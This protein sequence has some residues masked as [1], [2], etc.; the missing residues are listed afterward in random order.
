MDRFSTRDF[1]L[2]GYTYDLVIIRRDKRDRLVSVRMQSD[3]HHIYDCWVFI[4][5]K[6]QPMQN[7]CYYISFTKKRKLFLVLPSWSNIS[8]YFLCSQTYLEQLPPKEV[9]DCQTCI[10]NLPSHLNSYGQTHGCIRLTS[11]VIKKKKIRRKSLCKPYSLLDC[12]M[13]IGSLT[14]TCRSSAMGTLF[15]CI[16]R[17]EQNIVLKLE[18]L[19]RHLKIIQEWVELAKESRQ[20]LEVGGH[21]LQNSFVCWYLDESKTGRKL[22]M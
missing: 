8:G 22:G 3:L 11:M 12:I 7:C 4:T 16:I 18:K 9:V 5:P 21:N 17:L 6:H 2:E 10:I 1:K 20:N 19:V 15:L 13:G 14:Q